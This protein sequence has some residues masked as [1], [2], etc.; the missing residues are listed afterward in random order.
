[1][2][3]NGGAAAL[4][5]AVVKFNGGTR[6]V[7]GNNDAVAGVAGGKVISPAGTVLVP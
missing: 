6:P 4:D 1:L 3:L 2:Q 7:A 5:G